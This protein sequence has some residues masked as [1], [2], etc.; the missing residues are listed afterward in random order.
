M[1]PTVFPGALLGRAVSGQLGSPSARVQVWRLTAPEAGRGIPLYSPSGEEP[2]PSDAVPL[3]PVSFQKLRNIVVWAP[4]PPQFHRQLQCLPPFFLESSPYTWREGDQVPPARLIIKVSGQF[5]SR[6]IRY[7]HVICAGLYLSLLDPTS[8]LLPQLP[9]LVVPPLKVQNGIWT[10]CRIENLLLRAG[11]P[12]SSLLRS[13]PPAP[14]P[15]SVAE[16]DAKHA[17]E[18]EHF[19]VK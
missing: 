2:V 11:P 1:I 4:V 18:P 14:S 13:P 3:L 9:G 6:M 19:Q 5:R 12:L 15:Q 7:L 17:L 16:D 8:P 10:D